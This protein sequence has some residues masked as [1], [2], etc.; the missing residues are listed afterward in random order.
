MA[1]FLQY[2]PDRVTYKSFNDIIDFYFI[3][4]PYLRKAF[5]TIQ[6]FVQFIFSLNYNKSNERE[7]KPK[8]LSVK[9]YKPFFYVQFENNI[10]TINK[11]LNLRFPARDTLTIDPETNTLRTFKTKEI[12]PAFEN[13]LGGTCDNNKK[14]IWN[15]SKCET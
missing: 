1:I 2:N 12:G 15:K 10:K 13:K 6:E 4:A 5:N 8:Y 14:F 11:K 7:Q 3:R 9:S